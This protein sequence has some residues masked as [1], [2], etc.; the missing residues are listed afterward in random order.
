MPFIELK[1]QLSNNECVFLKDGS[2]RMRKE[3]FL[4]HTMKQNVRLFID[5]TEH[6]VGLAPSDTGYSVQIDTLSSVRLTL[7]CLRKHLSVGKHSIEWSVKHNMF[8]IREA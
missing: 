6:L 1:K 7:K 8:I 4:S 2:L 5:E 3:Y